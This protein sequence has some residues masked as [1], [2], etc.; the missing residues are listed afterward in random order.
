ML[1]PVLFDDEIGHLLSSVD[2]KYHISYNKTI[3]K[4]FRNC[5]AKQYNSLAVIAQENEKIPKLFNNDR[6]MDVTD[7]YLKTAE[8]K[9]KIKEQGDNRFAYLCVF[10]ISG[11]T[12]VHWAKI[13]NKRAVFNKM[14]KNIVYLPA[15]YKNETFEPVGEPFILTVNGK[16]KKIRP[17]KK[18]QSV[19]LY[20]KYFL[21][22]HTIYNASECIG[23]RFQGA[24]KPDLSDT[25]TLFTINKLAYSMTEV[26]VRDTSKYRYLI[27]QFNGMKQVSLAKLEFWGY[28][29]KSQ[30][31]LSGKCIGETWDNLFLS[32][33]L[34]L[35]RHTVQLGLSIYQPALCLL[36]LS[37]CLEQ[38]MKL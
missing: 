33:W 4:V 6:L 23:T 5:F 32:L 35:S 20:R 22:T 15:L 10:N 37:C 7:K 3:P 25:V 9:I 31:L 2:S 36:Y 27:F 17:R 21:S 34:Y 19:E 14:G 28:D 13:K 1:S 26:P 30:I 24:N 12:P 29:Y 18:T 8:V 16:M 38:S 11:W